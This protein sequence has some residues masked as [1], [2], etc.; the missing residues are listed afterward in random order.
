MV[1]ATATSFPATTSLKSTAISR[2]VRIGLFSMTSPDSV[3]LREVWISDDG[4]VLILLNTGFFARIRLLTAVCTNR[5][6]AHSYSGNLNRPVRSEG[7]AEEPLVPV[8][9]DGGDG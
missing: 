6:N 9:S 4:S 3:V 1:S 2:D 7:G 8:A 5:K